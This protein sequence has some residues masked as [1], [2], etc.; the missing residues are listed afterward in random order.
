MV[1]TDGVGVPRHDPA[2]LKSGVPTTGDALIVGSDVMPA[3]TGRTIVRLPLT[4]VAGKKLALPAW[5]AVI[6]Q[7][8]T[9]RIVI[10]LPLVVQIDRDA[11]VYVTGR[12]EE[13]VAPGSNADSPT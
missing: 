7:V 13:A 6:W 3:L 12:P 2:L 8:P 10:R 11:T 5:L 1:L 4:G 9:F